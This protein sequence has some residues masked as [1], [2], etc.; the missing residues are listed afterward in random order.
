VDAQHAAA[1]AFAWAGAV[2]FAAALGYFL[3]SYSVTFGEI[4]AGT[5]AP[6]AIAFDIALFSVFALH[7]S[8]FARIR[9]RAVVRRIVPEQLE[10]SAY[11]WVASLMLIG[12]CYNWRAVPGVLWQLSRPWSWAIAAVQLVGIWLTLR[13]A[14]VIDG[15]ELAGVRQVTIP[16]SQFPTPNSLESPNTEEDWKLEVGRWE[17]RTEGPYGWVRHPIYLGWILVVFSV[18]TMTMTRLVFAAISSV[19]LLIAIPFEERTIRAQSGG[20]YED[21]SRRVRWRLIPRVY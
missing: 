16:N 3:F 4:T 5:I 20:G 9:V 2:L 6:G 1:R 18:G 21:Y 17:F 14:A 10:R 7:H 13:S 19:Y 11:V 12:V 8:I 15:L